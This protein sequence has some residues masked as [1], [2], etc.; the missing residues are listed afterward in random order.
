MTGILN[1]VLG[2]GGAAAAQ[3]G[4]VAFTTV[5]TFSWVAPAGVTSVC[6]VC[7]GGGAYGFNNNIGGGGGGLGWKNNIAVTPGVSYTVVVGKGGISSSF[8]GGDSYFIDTSTVR[9]GGAPNGSGGTYTGD[10][11]GNGGNRGAYGGGGGAGGYTGNGG[12]GGNG[13][14]GGGGAG[15]NNGDI[16][17]GAGGGGVGLLGQGA[18]GTAGYQDAID[19]VT[20][21][22]GGSGGGDGADQYSGSGGGLYGG[23]GGGWYPDQD[24]PKGNGAR[25]AVRIIWGQGRSFPSTNTGNV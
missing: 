25:G 5:G 24:P 8:S 12:S 13:S 21:G 2:S 3:P 1:A 6:V 16:G 19:N 11:G 7:V 17:G 18:S 22:T 14:G 9:G 10:G 15:G 20:G 23:G 4:Q